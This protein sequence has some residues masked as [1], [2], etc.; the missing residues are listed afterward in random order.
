MTRLPSEG[1]NKTR[2]IPALGAKG[3][4]EFHDRLA[5]HAIGRVSSFRM[6][7][8]GRRLRVCLEGGTPIEGKS[9]LGDDGL[10]CREQ[11]D[12]DLGTRMRIASEEAF[13]GGARKV[14]IIGTDCPSID[15]IVLSDAGKLLDENDLVFGPALDGGYYL[16]GM[17]KPAMV[18][19]DGI[20]WG[21]ENVLSQSLDTA[22]LAG[23][24]TALLAPLPDVDLPDD[25]P[26]AELSL[27][28]GSTVS[29][30]IPTLNEQSRIEETL[31]CV[32]RSVPHEIIVAD[33]GSTDRTCE[34]ARSMG[35]HVLSAPKGRG[36]QMNL[37][38]E[39]AT[40]EFLLFLHADTTPP[41]DFPQI[42]A[43]IL[44]RP[45]TA[46]GAFRFSLAG[47]L[48]ASALIE[49]LVNLRCRFFGTPYGDQGIFIRRSMFMN[50]GG[51]PD[52]PVME[53]IH[54]IR[55]ARKAGT[56]RIAK[57]TALTSPRRWENGGLA[58]TFIRHQMMLILY[59]SGL[60]FRLISR[61]RE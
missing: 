2:L 37:G 54:L 26:A 10:D 48:G 42:I 36:S 41:E 22:K 31:A 58:R 47:D 56:I 55:K 20:S 8:K 5:R 35:V 57:E 11:A 13:A 12:G 29:V 16:V 34:I 1:R 33:G 38:A 24:K 59:R 52:W 4:M 60:P 50:L 7:G 61:R 14:V 19:F 28:I 39:A 15:E 40:G 9:W 49:S 43:E 25:L 27:R 53:D 45:N 17:R 51:F 3:A 44:N 18:I 21:G 23:M 30:I 6:L 32:S 46:A